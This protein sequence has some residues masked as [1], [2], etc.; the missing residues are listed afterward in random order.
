MRATA[1]A[2]AA[3]MLLVNRQCAAKLQRGI[4]GAQNSMTGA[5]GMIDD[6][7]DAAI[8]DEMMEPPPYP[9]GFEPEAVAS[10]D[11]LRLVIRH[12]DPEIATRENRRLVHKWSNYFSIYDQELSRFRNSQ[13]THFVEIGGF[14]GG[15]AQLW[16]EWLGPGATVHVVDIEQINASYFPPNV[17][18][19]QG[20]QSNVSFWRDEFLPEIPVI[21][22][23]LDDGGHTWLQQLITMRECLPHI[24][25]GGVL[26]VEDTHTSFMSPGEHAHSHEPQLVGRTLRLQQ[27]EEA[28]G[29]P[30]L[31][32]KQPKPLQVTKEAIR[33]GFGAW[34]NPTWAA[35]TSHTNVQAVQEALEQT[36]A[37]ALRGTASPDGDEL[38][39]LWTFV[40]ECKTLAYDLTLAGRIASA[41]DETARAELLKSKALLAASRR[42]RGSLL[43]A[44]WRELFVEMVDSISISDS[45]VTIRAKA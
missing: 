2:L 18:I 9:P 19:W 32:H 5:D 40:D 36:M 17:R 14:A 35:D 45:I 29:V 44:E 38:L 10:S 6:G 42:I 24:R 27:L 25:R 13:G 37:L 1:F 7:G 33:T 41:A 31:P 8:T 39:P 34:K 22:A 4:E 20:D 26:M 28:C 30:L 12:F 21:D 11:L 43:N 3:A 23:L 16:A 15:S